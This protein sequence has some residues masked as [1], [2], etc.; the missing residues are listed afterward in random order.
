[1][2]RRDDLLTSIRRRIP[3]SVQIGAVRRPIGLT[4]PTTLCAF[5]AV[6]EC[7]GTESEGRRKFKGGRGVAREAGF[8][9][10]GVRPRPPHR[11][12]GCPPGASSA[13][14][15]SAGESVLGPSSVRSWYRGA[16]WPSTCSVGNPHG[17]VTVGVLASSVM[18]RVLSQ[19]PGG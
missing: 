2:N 11:R 17:Q 1:M 8:S 15:N 12:S 18:G 19:V 14:A 13:D 7:G 16:L 6:P 3:L 9:V 4:S 5:A 10:E